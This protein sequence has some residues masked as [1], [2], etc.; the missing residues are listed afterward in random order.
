MVVVRN[1]QGLFIQG[2]HHGLGRIK[3]ALLAEAMGVR[4]VWRLVNDCKAL[5][6]ELNFLSWSIV[7]KSMNQVPHLLARAP[8]SGSD[9]SEWGFIPSAHICDVLNFDTVQ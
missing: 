7:R 6:T 4:E 3:S 1:A 5:E 9:F 8:D 2:M